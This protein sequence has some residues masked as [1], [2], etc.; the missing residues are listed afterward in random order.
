MFQ[1]GR[2]IIY[3]PRIRTVLSSYSLLEGLQTRIARQTFDWI[4]AL[5][6]LNMGPAWEYSSLEILQRKSKQIKVWNFELAGIVVSENHADPR[7]LRQHWWRR[8]PWIES[9]LHWAKVDFDFE[10]PAGEL[11]L[12]SP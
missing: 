10:E 4:L 9:T 1:T 3:G 8:F 6:P 11:L 7:L 5:N 2:F 12:S